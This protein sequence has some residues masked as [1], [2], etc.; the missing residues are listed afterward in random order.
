MILQQSKS[1]KTL[2]I[3]LLLLSG[4][5]S[6]ASAAYANFHL[7]QVAEGIYLHHGVH[8]EIE[9]PQHDDIANIGFIVGEKCIAVV[10]TGGSV[11]VGKKLLN[12]IRKT[13]QLPICYVINTH[14]HFDHVLGSFAFVSGNT[15]FVGHVRLADAI[16]YNRGF[17]LRQFKENL[18]SAPNKTSIIAPQLTV[19]DTMELDLGNR[20]IRLTA[21]DIAHSDSD[22]TVFDLKTNT[23]WAGDLVF[24]ERIPILDGK[25]K[26]WLAVMSMFENQQV[27][28]LIPGHGSVS[29]E[30]PQAYYAHKSYLEMLLTD[31]KQAIAEGIFLDEARQ[32]IGQDYKQ[33]WLLHEH[34]HGRNVIKAFTELE[35]EE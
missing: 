11:A 12:A 17:F 33:Q 26:N 30:W 6:F 15:Q 19:D 22:L 5:C 16:E 34:Y 31:T 24:R 13:S 2:T 14:I 9:H 7:E 28:L 3:L 25:L 20:V 27:N 21:Y 35:W 32:R 29:S 4:H 8:V 1:V 23:L 18:G 10:D